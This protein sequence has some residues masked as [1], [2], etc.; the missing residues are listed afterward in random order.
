MKKGMNEACKSCSKPSVENNYGFCEDHRDPL[1]RARTK[2]TK[3]QHTVSKPAKS[4]LCHVCEEEGTLTKCADNCIHDATNKRDCRK[5][6]PGN[7][8]ECIGLTSKKTVRIRDCKTHGK[9]VMCEVSAHNIG[10]KEINSNAASS[11]R[12]DLDMGIYEVRPPRSAARR[13]PT[14][15]WTWTW[16]FR[17]FGLRGD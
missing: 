4:K 17:K 9:N 8:C 16:A 3:R 13:L 14:C 12:L 15:A 1:H 10:K 2:G 7:Y 6:S 5:C 11:W